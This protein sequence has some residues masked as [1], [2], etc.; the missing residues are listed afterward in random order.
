MGRATLCVFYQPIQRTFDP[1]CAL[2]ED[3]GVEH[4]GANVS[5]SQQFLYRADVAPRLQKVG[6]KAMS[7]GVATRRLQYAG[8]AHRHLYRAL[9]YC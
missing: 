3:V 2:T 9:H 4:G 5:M 6:G 7:K 8:A 1:H